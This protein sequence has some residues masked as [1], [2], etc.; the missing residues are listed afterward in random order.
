MFRCTQTGK[1]NECAGERVG[2]FHDWWYD[3]AT[4]ERDGS[5]GLELRHIAWINPN[6]MHPAA[7]PVDSKPV[8]NHIITTPVIP[9]FFPCRRTETKVER[10]GGKEKK[11]DALENQLNAYLV[12]RFVIGWYRHGEPHFFFLSSFASLDPGNARG[13]A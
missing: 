3:L 4:N 7:Q 12:P 8:T 5:K 6:P 11:G 10:I 2:I 13:R 9:V 1:G